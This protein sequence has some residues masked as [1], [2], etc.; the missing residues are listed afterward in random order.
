MS[1]FL[2]TNKDDDACLKLFELIKM[3]MS[4]M[5]LVAVVVFIYAV[6]PLCVVCRCT[7]AVFVD[8]LLR[9][10]SNTSGSI[11]GVKACI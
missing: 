11:K 4:M 3:M 6:M 2:E 5:P 1:K 7:V 8:T 10:C 9:R